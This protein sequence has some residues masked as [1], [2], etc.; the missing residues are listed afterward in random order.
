[1]K[2]GVNVDHVATL[3]QA[4]KGIV[5]D[6]VWAA[7][8][9][10]KAG[11]HAVV[12]H[13]REDRRHIQDKDLFRAKEVL[14]IKLNLE[15]SLAPEIVRIALTLRPEQ[16]TLVPERRKEMTTESGLNLFSE[17]ERV[18][19]ALDGFKR[20]NILASLFIDPD[21]K[22]IDLAREL[23]ADAVEFHTGAYANQET[24][25][26]FKD[27]LRRLRSAVTKA[28]T[29]GLVAHAG[30]GLDYQNV[31]AVAKI[32]GLAELNIGYSIVTRALCVGLERAVGEMLGLIQK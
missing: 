12:M 8:I 5:P 7:G 13:L 28:G 3:R 16:V 29:L 19:R 6:P 24:A 10:Q 14:K 26:G 15:M 30:H 2:L 4:R 21:P 32:K 31:R 23:K 25:L 9:C 11:A 27:E 18:K 1:V 17:K 20:K 22:Q